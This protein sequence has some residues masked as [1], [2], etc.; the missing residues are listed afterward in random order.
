MASLG[1]TFNADSV[2][3]RMQEREPI[4][5]GVYRLEVVESDVQATKSG[6]GEMIKLTLRVM[7][8]PCED[9]TIWWNI[10][11]RNATATAQE[12]GQREFSALCHAVGVLA[13]NETEE[14]HY[15]P[16]TAKVGVEPAK[17]DYG[18]KNKIVKV[19][20]EGTGLTATPAAAPAAA[21]VAAPA[22]PSARARPWA[23]K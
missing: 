5:A 13:P 15:K 22:A 17:G 16:F 3:P 14:L 18:P 12:I 10:N 11:Y 20:W 19:D 1:S 6:N 21:V 7:E 9:R 2:D 8:G 4:P 23:T